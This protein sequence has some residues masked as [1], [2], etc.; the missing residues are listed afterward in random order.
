M[1]LGLTAYL[2]MK[3]GEEH[4]F[5]KLDFYMIEHGFVYAQK[6]GGYRDPLHQS[7]AWK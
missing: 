6:I 1:T 7:T 3:T 2:D 5:R 4:V